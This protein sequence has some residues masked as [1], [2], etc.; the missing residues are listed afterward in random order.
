MKLFKKKVITRASDANN[1]IRLP[2][3]IRWNIFQCRWFS[4][5]LHRILLSDD[6]CMHDHPWTFI[7]FILQGGYVECTPGARS[8]RRSQQPP[9]GI[10]HLVDSKKYENKRLY[11]AGSI[12]YRPAKFIHRLDIYQPALTLV[13]TFRKTKSWGFFTP[14]GF[15]EWFNYNKNHCA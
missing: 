13:I 10:A 1:F 3:L 9:H 5:K 15:I 12:L 11:G 2:Y 7:S 14:N 4:I 8:I 6:D